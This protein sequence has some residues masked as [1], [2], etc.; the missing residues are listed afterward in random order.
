MALKDY[1]GSPDIFSRTMHVT[2]SNIAEGLAAS[3]V[4]V[5]GEGNEQTPIATISDVPFIDFVDRNPTPNELKFLLIDKDDDVY[6]SILG[7]VPWK[8]GKGK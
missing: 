6:G 5:M 1:I 2:K 3:C 7:S 8:K 4:L